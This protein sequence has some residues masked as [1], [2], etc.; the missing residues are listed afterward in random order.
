M[1]ERLAPLSVRLAALWVLAVSAIK[2]FLGDPGSLPEPFRTHFLGP[3]LNFRLSISVEF[4]VAALALLHPRW[5]FLALCTL[6][7]VFVPVLVYLL[8]TGAES[9]GCFGGALKFP[10]AAMLAVDGSLLAFMLATRPLR[11]IAPRPAPKL[12]LA[13]SFAVAAALPWLVVPRAPTAPVESAQGGWRLPQVLPRYAVLRPAEWE[14]QPIE[15]SE[16]AVWMDVAQHSPDATWILYRINC[17]HCAELLQRLA[18]EY[19]TDPKPY[20][21]VAFREPRDEAERV[22]HVLPPGEQVDLTDSVA[23]QIETP[24]TLLLEGGLVRRAQFVE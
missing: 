6:M 18:A 4:A 20:V 2:L 15:R 7:G 14:G 17:P 1:R 8:A 3:D 16:L 5:G 22:V 24:W 9:C 13:A 19:P 12:A 23:W 10:P 11:S 21:L